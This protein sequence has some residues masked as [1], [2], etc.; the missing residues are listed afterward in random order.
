MMVRS[1]ISADYDYDVEES[2]DLYIDQRD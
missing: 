2:D 1:E